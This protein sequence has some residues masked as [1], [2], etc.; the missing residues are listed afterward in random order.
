MIKIDAD[1]LKQIMQVAWGILFAI[2]FVIWLV[3]ML[4]NYSFAEATLMITIDAIG[5][6]I[7]TILL[8]A[9][10]ILGLNEK[11]EN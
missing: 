1:R 7:V 8:V 6:V 3:S 4:G 2:I 9:F 11:E 5:L 10:R